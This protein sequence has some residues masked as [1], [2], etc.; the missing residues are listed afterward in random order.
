MKDSVL[1]LDFGDT[2][3][4]AEAIRQCLEWFGY[5][6]LKCNIGRPI[7]F[8][9]VLSGDYFAEYKY[10]IISCHEIDGEIIMPELQESVYTADEPKGNFGAHEISKYIKLEGK[11]IINTGC[12]TGSSDEMKKA[13]VSSSNFYISPSGDPQGNSSLFFVVSLF[14]YLKNNNLID[15]VNLAKL[16][17]K[18]TI[19]FSILGCDN[20]KAGKQKTYNKLVR[21]KIPEIIKNSGSTAETEILD[22]QTYLKML[23][24]KLL[25]EC[26]E[27]IGASDNDSKIEEMADVL[28][29]LHA[30]ADTLGVTM[31]RVEVVRLDKQ[32]KRGSF[33][34]KI[35]LKSTVLN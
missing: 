31:S 2:G 35:L 19:L 21:D 16:A 34:K 4:E 26:N 24:E 28:E 23:D 27:L 13:F 3:N 18:E 1:L 33:K 12:S 30:I 8:I 9:K 10:L 5:D 7:D 32:K 20:V 22:N 17:N 11:I 6:V 14:Y 29:V 15:S 25:E